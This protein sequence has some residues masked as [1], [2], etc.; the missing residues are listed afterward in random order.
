[1]ATKQNELPDPWVFWDT[2][3]VAAHLTISISRFEGYYAVLLDF[4]KCSRLPSEKGK[5]KKV[6]KAC[7][8]V[9]WSYKNV[10]GEVA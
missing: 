3:T 1:M 6:W 7:E 4:P 9:T 2:K 5:G 8:V 10:T